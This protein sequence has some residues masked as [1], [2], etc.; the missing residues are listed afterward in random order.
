MKSQA[1]ILSITNPKKFFGLVKY[2]YSKG[3]NFIIEIDNSNNT[4]S[5]ICSKNDASIQMLHTFELRDMIHF[6][7]GD[8]NFK[9]LSFSIDFGVKPNKLLD[10]LIRDTQECILT[11]QQVNP[12]QA[13][14]IKLHSSDRIMDFDFDEDINS[15]Q[16]IKPLYDRL[17]LLP[18]KKEKTLLEFALPSYILKKNL[19]NPKKNLWLYLLN[20]IN[21]Q[22]ILFSDNNY[23]LQILGEFSTTENEFAVLLHTGHLKYLE[24]EEYHVK[25]YPKYILFISKVKDSKFYFSITNHYEETTHE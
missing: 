24:N 21:G 15:I 4:I 22:T 9:N 16:N 1:I 13:N 12:S 19:N 6:I 11:L 18:T 25:V 23:N 8:I 7:S 3:M 2:L 14:V 5:F 10:Y 20:K 17:K